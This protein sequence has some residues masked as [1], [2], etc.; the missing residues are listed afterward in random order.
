[1]YE[2]IRALAALTRTL[3]QRAALEDIL[4]LVVEQAA[5]LLETSR[6]SARLLDPSRTRLLAMSRAGA[7]LHRNPMSEFALGEGL[8]GW[9]AHQGQP[10]RS[11]DAEADARF[12]R[13]AEQT[14][15][16]GSFLGVPLLSAG[17]CIGVLS[18][19]SSE[20]GY[21][22]DYHEDTLTILAGLCSP[23]LEIARLRRLS[24]VDPLTGAL[25]RRGLELVWPD[26]PGVLV[27]EVVVPSTSAESVGAVI[28]VDIDHFKRVNDTH[29][30]P[31]GDE[32]LRKVA[33]RLAGALRG[34]DA[35]IR[36]GG[37]EF[38]LVLETS[39]AKHA[40]HV[41]ERARVM[42]EQAP[43]VVGELSL[44]LT[45]SCGVAEARPGERR[46]ALIERADAALYSAKL[47]GRNRV[48]LA[49]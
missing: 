26:S 4:Q 28:M 49:P 1:M 42:I 19:I 45:I 11:D 34:G 7:P 33:A 8:I 44:R 25:N 27:D 29:G 39:G 6:V 48:A 46:D 17:S 38:L 37:E 10:L 36:Y 24:Q 43:F 31:V 16:L 12:V 2:P 13:R 14:E 15:R 21:F 20:R 47:D 30:H 5:S 3:R 9:V 40:A 41:A 22:R 18:A 32:V 23:Y 35:V